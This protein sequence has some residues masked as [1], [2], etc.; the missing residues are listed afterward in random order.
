MMWETTVS[1]TRSRK[2]KEP[3]EI[4][5]HHVDHLDLKMKPSISL[6]RQDATSRV[7]L[8]TWKASKKSHFWN[9]D[10]VTE[11]AHLDMSKNRA[12]TK[13]KKGTTTNPTI[14]ATEEEDRR[15]QPWE[16]ER[17]TIKREKIPENV[18]ENQRIQRDKN[19]RTT[20][21]TKKHKKTEQT[22]EPDGWQH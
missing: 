6:Q 2:K 17:E 16:N 11:Q 4:Y 20:E 3:K 18:L 5:V 1:K 15:S 10:H 12:F 14:Q 7:S 21:R 22:N 13:T 8:L 19:R 9:S